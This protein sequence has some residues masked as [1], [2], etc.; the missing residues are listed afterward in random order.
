MRQQTIDDMLETLRKYDTV[1]IV[2]DSSSMIGA[3][4]AEAASALSALADLAGQFDADGIDIHFLNDDRV[5]KNMTKREAV[6]DLFNQIR[7]RGVTPIGERLEDLLRDYLEKLEAAYDSGNLKSIKPV[8]FVVLTDGAPTD[9]PESVIVQAA[10]RLDAKHFPLS[11]VGIQ[12]VQIGKSAGAA[13]YLRELDDNL[14]SQ[15][16]IR[17]IVDTTK[18]IGKDLSADA[19]VKILL[20]GINRRV[21]NKGVEVFNEDAMKGPILRLEGPY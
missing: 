10:R 16:H 20:G 12:F 3:R 19:L 6:E 9:D 2:D 1:I 11:Q 18:Y 5:G 13:R 21:D 8:N 15:Y 4:W 14:V 17:D 7:P